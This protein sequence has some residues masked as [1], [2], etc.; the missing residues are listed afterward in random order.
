MIFY[1]ALNGNDGNAGTKEHPF[2]TITRARDAVRGQIRQGLREPITVLVKEGVYYTGNITLDETD[3]G[4]EEFPITYEA[5]GNVVLNGGIQL[6]ARMF[7]PLTRE[8][9]SRLHGLAAENVLRVDLHKLGISRRDYG[10]M[11]VTGSHHT[12][13][14]Y[15][16]AV[17]SPLWC[18]L[19]VN[20][21]RQTIAR[22]PNEGFL[23]TEAP[24]REGDG[25]ESKITGKVIYRYTLEEWEK[26]RNP[27]SDIY[28]L[29]A[30]TAK[31]AATWKTLR[32]VWMFGYPTWNWA[33]MS[34][35][36]VRIDGEKGEMETQMVS[37]Y[38]MKSHAP[39]YFYNVFEELD[40]PGEWYLNRDTGFLYLYPPC[41][42]SEAEITLSLLT[43][44]ILT[45][46]NVSYVRIKGLT[47]SATRADAL[48]LT[49]NHLTVENC[50]VK[51][52]AENAMVIKGDHIRVCGCEM[53]H[54]GRGGV[55]IDGGDRVTLTPSYNILENNHVHHISEIFTTYQPA[56]SLNGVGNLCRNNLI[57]DSTHMAIYFSGNDHVIEYNEIHDV[58]K[59]AD[60]SSAVYAGRDYSTQ[61]TVIRFNYFHDIKSVAKNE[62]GVYAVYCDDN[63]GKCTI[64]QNVFV[65]C[66]SALL[67][68]GGHNMTFRGNVIAEACPKTKNALLFGRYHYWDDLL[69]EGL[70]M[71]RLNEVPWQSEIWLK[72]YPQ[73]AEY[74][75]WHPE[76]EQRFPHYADIS[77]NVIIDH[78]PIETNFA[79]DD[80]RYKNKM[81]NNV[82]LENVPM[83]DLGYLCR[84][85][86]PETVADFQP[87]PFENI[88][89]LKD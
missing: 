6:C 50:T 45:M 25:L 31:R 26:K 61:G 57:H 52:I 75:S 3:S 2:A 39:Y 81:E 41:P 65:R 82:Y 73:I 59:T 10:E 13:D 38:G 58:C 87:I 30:D 83:R 54:L 29:D 36:I 32:D 1:V 79:W 42:L 14:R 66:Q 40:T 11:C 53:H 86:L 48:T 69:P 12:G 4:T 49:G 9:K 33:G 17:L 47:F 7:E 62:V 44:S 22:Y 37:R 88:G 43:E 68:H 67:L 78:A 76:H 23:Y 84:K 24:V 35:P 56:F 55:V 46:K 85:Y 5:V 8:E 77:G 51:N 34:T 28:G 60:D 20:D 74:L 18:E 71:K 27:V 15:D 63:L 89:V 16:G 80:P 21:M 19:F 70:H 64:V 72:A